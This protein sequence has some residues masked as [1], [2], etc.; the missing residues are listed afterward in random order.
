MSVLG[1]KYPRTVHLR[2]LGGATAEGAG[3]LCLAIVGGAILPVIQGVVADTLSI[4][5]SF[6]VPLASYGFVTWYAQKGSKLPN[7]Q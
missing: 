3:L 6:I 1:K 7:E 4:Q 5:M 2:N